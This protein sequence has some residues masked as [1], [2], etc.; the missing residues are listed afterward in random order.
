MVF[1]ADAEALRRRWSRGRGDPGRAALGSGGDARVLRVAD[2]RA[3]VC[4][5]VRAL[6]RQ[7]GREQ[8][9]HATAVIEASERR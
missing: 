6:V 4:A 2:P 1:A 7:R 8:G 3:G 5:G 9:V